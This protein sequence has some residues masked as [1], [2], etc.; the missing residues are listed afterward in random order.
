MIKG[1]RGTSLVDFPG[2]LAAVIFF[3]GCNFRCPFCYNVDLVSPARLRALP[4][5]A[6]EDIL[7]ELARR[8]GFITGVVVTGGEPTL[9]PRHLRHLLEMIRAETKLAIKLDTNGSAPE[10]VRELAEEGLVDYV[11]VDFKTSPARYG[12]LSGR[13]D[14]VSE[15]LSYLAESGLDHEVRITAVPAFVSRAELAEMVPYLERVPRV[16][17]QRFMSEYERLQPELDLGLYGPEELHAL[18]DFLAERL[19]GEVVL[20]H[21]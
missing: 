2:H 16:A 12:E 1:F 9:H 8:E 18:R 17:L 14:P 7:E 13:F 4:S 6:P 15:T 19:G 10:V 11:A 20:R 21:V 5:L 3:G